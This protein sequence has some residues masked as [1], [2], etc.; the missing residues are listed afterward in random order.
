MKKKIGVVGIGIMGKYH[1][2][3]LLSLK[4]AK[5]MGVFDLDIEKA[6]NIA[7]QFNIPSFDSLP[8]LIEISDAMIISSPTSTHFELATQCLNSKKDVF[9]EKPIAKTSS[10]AKELFDL[11]QKNNCLIF[12]GM[13]ERFNPA[14]RKL[15][16][17]SRKHRILGILSK[18]LSPNPVR[19][20]DTNV[21]FDLMIHDIDLAMHLLKPSVEKIK[22]EGKKNGQISNAKAV[23]YFKDGV[24]V[25]LE[26]SWSAENKAREITVITDKG[27]Y[28][29]DLI[30]KSLSYLDFHDLNSNVDIEI[31][32]MD[33]ITMELTAFI[34]ALN[35]KDTFKTNGEEIIKGMEAAEEV[36]KE[37][38]CF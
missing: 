17:L 24:V 36:E 20:Q 25:H 1:L 9:I 27:I 38:L 7:S 5:L 35:K 22:A 23:L 15:S 21:I 32:Q 4:G 8:S 31:D 33:Q 12:T 14:I 37:I 10:E 2:E 29:S 13:I 19:I 34:K 11:A 18:R 28:R 30:K 3:K 16:K 6:K 26:A